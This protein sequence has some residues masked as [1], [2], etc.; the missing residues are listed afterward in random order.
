MEWLACLLL[1]IYLLAAELKAMIG[2]KGRPE[3]SG[4]LPSAAVTAGIQALAGLHAGR[5]V[6]PDGNAVNPAPFT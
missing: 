2:C 5:F 6:L 4:G 1:K 3:G